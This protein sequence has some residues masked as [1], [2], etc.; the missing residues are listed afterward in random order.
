MI[1]GLNQLPTFLPLLTKEI[2][3]PFNASL[4]DIMDKTE[5]ILI[6]FD[7]TLLFFGPWFWQFMNRDLIF[8]LGHSSFL[9]LGSS[10][11]HSWLRAN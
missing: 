7:G 8:P 1:P 6:A 5:A 11:I 10:N 4:K 2:L 3:Q 9:S